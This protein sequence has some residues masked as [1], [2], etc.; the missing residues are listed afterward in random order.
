MRCVAIVSDLSRCTKVALCRV[1]DR[2]FCRGHVGQ[3]RG[4][5]TRIIAAQE[6]GRAEYESA[7]RAIARCQRIND[8]RFRT[9]R[10]HA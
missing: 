5:Q 8:E 1:G 4:E 3:A 7:S 2:G 10:R 9:H 6:A